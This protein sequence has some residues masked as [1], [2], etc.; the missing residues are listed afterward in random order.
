MG[1]SPESAPT[2]LAV[3]GAAQESWIDWLHAHAKAHRQLRVPFETQMGIVTLHLSLAR[4]HFY[5]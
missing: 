5:G 2:R 3:P 1:S 4:R